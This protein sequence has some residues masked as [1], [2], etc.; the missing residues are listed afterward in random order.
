MVAREASHPG[1]HIQCS[2]AAGGLEPDSPLSSSSRMQP[3]LCLRD[4]I[5]SPIGRYTLGP[6]YLVWFKTAKLSGMVF[7]GRPKPEHV[8]SVTRAIDIDVDGGPRA[9]IV[10]ARRVEYVAPETFDILAS[11]VRS[12]TEKLRERVSA[13]ALLCP[14][15]LVGAV[16]AGFYRLHVHL[17]RVEVFTDPYDALVWLG[18]TDQLDVISEA[19]RIVDGVD[20][21]SFTVRAI[22]DHVRE[23]LSQPIS[24]RRVATSL[25]LSPRSLQRCLSEANSSYRAELAKARV[26]VAKRLLREAHYSIKQVALEIGCSSTSALD[27]LFRKVEGQSPSDWRNRVLS[28]C[29]SGASR[30]PSA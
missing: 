1:V 3:S 22:R 9:S 20:E 29:P 24:L 2:R 26:D 7:W 4:Y 6:T 27:V 15:G 13:Q 17:H 21:A 19:E 18:A 30:W 16:V 25:G 23:N 28:E 5:A 10:D 11:Y 8:E 12:H 14:D